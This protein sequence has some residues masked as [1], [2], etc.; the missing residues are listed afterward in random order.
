MVSLTVIRGLREANGSWKMICMSRRSAFMAFLSKL[1]TSWSS[2]KTFPSVGSCSRR[3]VLPKVDFPQPDSP[4]TPKVSPL[5]MEKLTSSTAWRVPL[6]VWKY[7]FRCSTL[8]RVVLVA[9]LM[10]HLLFG[11]D[12]A[13]L[14]G[15]AER[16]GRRHAAGAHLGGILAPGGE[17]TTGRQI[18]R[19]GHQTL[20]GAEPSHILGQ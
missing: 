14:M 1:V 9:S 11:E 17:G 8:S 13:D 3:M 4:T 6:F 10:G 7:F 15:I 20:D 16:I 19:I 2:K 18:G 5:L 12:T